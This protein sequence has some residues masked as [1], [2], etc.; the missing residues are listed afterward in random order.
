[1][2]DSADSTKVEEIS[3]S[4]DAVHG[5][6]QT[7]EEAQGQGIQ[8]LLKA[9]DFLSQNTLFDVKVEG[10][11]VIAADSHI[12]EDIPELINEPE[13][14][15]EAKTLP[16]EVIS[17]DK[18]KSQSSN[19]VY[20]EA[21]VIKPLASIEECLELHFKAEM[22][23]WTCD[24]CSKAAQNPGIIPGKYS[25]PMMSSTNQDT[26]VDGDQTE[27]SEKITG[28][29]EQSS[30]L[31]SSAVEGTSS[32]MQPHGSDS[33]N[34]VMLTVDSITK[35]ITITPGRIC[36]EQ[37]LASDSI[38]NK[39]PE[40]H[41]GAQEA[42]PSCIPAEK[43]ANLLSCQDQNAST[44]DEGRGEEVKL[45]HSALQVEEN[46]SEQ[47]DMNKGAIQTRLI[48]KLP[49]V[50]V[51]H[52][53]RSLRS[54]KV[55][56]HVSFKEILDMGLFVD[57]SYEDKDN[58]SYRLAGVVEH[59]GHGNDAGHYVAYVRASHRQQ[60]SGSSSWFLANDVNIKEISLEKVLECEA[61]L[62]FYERMEG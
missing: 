33:Q 32:S 58:S 41:D 55:I 59:R 23:E 2:L 53:K 40:S 43:R 37:D 20:N 35:G 52:L 3:Q 16:A 25:E 36:V 42:I 10:M 19:T 46:Q 61:Y 29:N 1:M 60:T 8:A 5:P 17:E 39:K 22:I 62:L 38:A 47:E 18:G 21:E 31:N 44:L 57:P 24:S 48:S 45:H 51:I 14:I 4:S 11:D 54:D 27:Q 6:L 50:L 7:Q 9:V 30:N 49:P 26:T 34:Q 28:R 56:G 15:A 12:P 13:L